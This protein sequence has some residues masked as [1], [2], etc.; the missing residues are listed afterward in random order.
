MSTIPYDSPEETWDGYDDEDAVRI[1]PRR[2]RQFL[3]WGSALLFAAL[4]GGACFYAGVRVEKGQLSSSSSPLSSLASARGGASALGARG[5]L[6]AGAASL[7]SRG[8]GGRTGSFF[9]GGLGGAGGTFGTV[10]SVNGKTVYVTEAGGDVVKVTLSS[11]TSIT[12]SEN[13]SK[14]A[15]QPGD[16]VTVQGVKGQSGAIAATSVSDSGNRSGGAGTSASSSSSS[17]S[18]AVSSL[19]SGGG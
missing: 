13:A 17:S 3:N 7:F 11:A 14:S 9:P 8:G 12:K 10:S 16:S 18:S 4:V 15:I 2:R 19:F 6:G 1:P 5:R